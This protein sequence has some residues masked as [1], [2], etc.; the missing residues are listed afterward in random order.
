MKIISDNR[1]KRINMICQC[2]R[3]LEIGIG[4]IKN[5]NGF[6]CKSCYIVCPI[7]NKHIPL[8][9]DIKSIISIY[10]KED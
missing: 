2:G 8:R 5:Y 6:F 4:D 7:C 1:N 9:N 3:A 10:G